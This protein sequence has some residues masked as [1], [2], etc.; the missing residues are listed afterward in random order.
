MFT[1]QHTRRKYVI[2][3]WFVALGRL[4]VNVYTYAYA[5]RAFGSERGALNRGHTKHPAMY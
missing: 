5:I 4:Y 1:H 3:Q 2:E